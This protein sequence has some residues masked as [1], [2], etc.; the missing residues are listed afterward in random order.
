M[1]EQ[2]KRGSIIYI[3]FDPSTGAEIQ[4]RRPAVVVSD[5]L[6]AETSPFAWVVPI[7]HGS[8]NGV[9]YPLHVHLDSRTQV[10][11]TVY[12]EQIKSFDFRKR[13]WQFVEECPAD[14]FSEIIKKVGLVVSD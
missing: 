13:K 11:G 8:F 1:V 3:D 12:V 10:D 9:D 6:L 2:L 4:K 7:S 5:D 14:I